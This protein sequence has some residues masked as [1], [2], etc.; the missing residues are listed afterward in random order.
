MA[1]PPPHEVPQGGSP[2]VQRHSAAQK[3]KPELQEQYEGALSNNNNLKPPHQRDLEA[4]GRKRLD[5][6]S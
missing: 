4:E 6:D 5:E 2:S 1:N 3:H